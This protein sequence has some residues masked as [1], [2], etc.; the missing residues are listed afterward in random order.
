[1]TDYFFEDLSR[2]IIGHALRAILGESG[3][4]SKL[5]YF[6]NGLTDSRIKAWATVS[7]LQVF[8]VKLWIKN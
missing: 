8:E 2:S 7:L 1:M 3:E 5:G 6:C 4:K